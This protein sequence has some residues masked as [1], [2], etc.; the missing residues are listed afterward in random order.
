[1]EDEQL[2]Q[3]LVSDS[4]SFGKAVDILKS[5]KLYRRGLQRKIIP[6]ELAY[7]KF[8]KMMA[9]VGQY[10]NSFFCAVQNGRGGFKE[11]EPDKE[12]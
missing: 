3:E 6:D 2:R 1:M 5:Y 7:E 8:A 4:L 12:G 9:D 10:G 11:P